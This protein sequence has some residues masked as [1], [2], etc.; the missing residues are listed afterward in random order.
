MNKRISFY[1]LLKPLSL[2]DTM[3][4]KK[5]VINYFN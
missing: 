1:E 4:N 3:Y 5:F 2:T